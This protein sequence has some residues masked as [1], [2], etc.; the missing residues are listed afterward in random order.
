MSQAMVDLDHRINQS[1]QGY[2]GTPVA[3]RTAA[4]Y[5]RLVD[6]LARTA[7]DYATAVV[8]ERLATKRQAQKQIGT[9]R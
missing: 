3:D 9:R 2:L 7:M 4:Q 1:L 6:Q 5:N 8:E